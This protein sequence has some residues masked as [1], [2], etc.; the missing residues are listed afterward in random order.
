MQ[1]LVDSDLLTLVR[2]GRTVAIDELLE[3]LAGETCTLGR[4]GVT[5]DEARA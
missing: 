1:R 3:R 4:L 2:D 5:L